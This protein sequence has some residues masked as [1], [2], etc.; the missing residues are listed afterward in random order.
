MA[1][2]CLSWVP[3][4]HIWT[5]TPFQSQAAESLCR[6]FVHVDRD[7][8]VMERW[9][10]GARYEVTPLPD[11]MMDTTL[12]VG[13]LDEFVCDEDLSQLFQAASHLNS[14]PACVVRK[15]DMTSLRYGLVTFPS[16]EEK[17]VRLK[18]LCMLGCISLKTD[19]RC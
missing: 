16:K 8:D 1:R 13:N 5:R 19:L 3:Q 15:P 11:S 9:M 14:V 4:R 7:A 12:F 6:R 18:I 10:G 2:R 17:E